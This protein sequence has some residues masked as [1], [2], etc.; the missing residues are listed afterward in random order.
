[1]KIHKANFKPLDEPLSQMKK[2]NLDFRLQLRLL[3][4]ISLFCKVSLIWYDFRS[5]KI[6]KKSLIIWGL[7][8]RQLIEK[9]PKELYFSSSESNLG[10]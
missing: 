1:M 6:Q 9:F 5:L 4:Y 7:F 2:Y 8:F 10:T 3:F